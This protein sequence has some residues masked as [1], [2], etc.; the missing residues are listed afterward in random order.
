MRQAGAVGSSAAR[1]SPLWRITHQQPAGLQVRYVSQSTRSPAMAQTMSASFGPG[2]RDFQVGHNSGSINTQIHL[3]PGKGYLGTVRTCP[4]DVRISER[5]ETRPAPFATIPFSR[6]PDFVN[7]G[8]ILDQIDKRWGQHLST[9]H[10]SNW[11]AKTQHRV[12]PRFQ[13]VHRGQLIPPFSLQ[14][15]V[16]GSV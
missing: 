4:A 1:P 6:D 2:N 3:P 7:R 8:D 16:C 12:L 9:D 15:P 5:P 11:R 10:R 13:L 14:R